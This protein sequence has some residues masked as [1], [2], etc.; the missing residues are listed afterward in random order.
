MLQVPARAVSGLVAPARPRRAYKAAGR[1]VTLQELQGAP[2]TAASSA[3]RNV[4]NLPP[5]L[6]PTAGAL[7]RSPAPIRPPIL[8]SSPPTHPPSRGPA[9]GGARRIGGADR[10]AGRRPRALTCPGR[11]ARARRR[12]SQS[13][14]AEPAGRSLRLARGGDASETPWKLRALGEP[15]RAARRWL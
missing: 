6:P 3:S 1:P 8:P 11:R 10:A 9:A 15:R 13:E 12:R 2:P 14:A 7:P 5:R 4:W